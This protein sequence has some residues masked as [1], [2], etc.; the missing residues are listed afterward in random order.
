MSES[1][2]PPLLRFEKVDKHFNRNAV[3]KATTLEFSRG[4]FTALIGASGAGKS[5]LLRLANG[6]IRPDA[7]EIFFEGA[8]TSA[9]NLMRLRRR[10]GFVFQ[11][12][13]LFPHMT[14]AENI[15]IG[16][17]IAGVPNANELVE[18]MLALVE[19]PPS[20]AS[21]F[22]NELSGGQQQR[23]GIARA[24]APTPTLLL[25]DEPF[26]AL[27]PVT[28]DSLAKRL[29][30]LHDQLGLTTIIVTHDVVEALLLADRVLV[31][32]GGRITADETPSALLRG[33]GGS[34]AQS[35]IEVPRAQA[36]RL[37]NL[38]K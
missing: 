23:V 13:A 28:R 8:P 16:A 32:V 29:R 14:V 25:L 37:A 12:I 21:R 19:L 22:P 11:S 9:F 15:T 5:T 38:Q 33:A 7:G 36:H 26:A 3:L 18:R 30:S 1:N 6:L 27:D 2:I 24:L 20:F 10:V 35:L 31:M 4:S 34:A 17:R